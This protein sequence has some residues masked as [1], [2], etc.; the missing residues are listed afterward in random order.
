MKIIRTKRKTLALEISSNASLIIRAPQLMP[1]FLIK[2]F[3]KEKQ[4]WI[5]K[6]QRLIKDRNKK[7]Q[8]IAPSKISKEKAL[9]KI[10]KRVEHYSSLSGF[11]YNQIKITSAQKRWGSCSANNNLNFP[12]KLAL[13][14]DKVIDYVVVHELCHIKEKNHSQKFWNEVSKLMPEYKK[15]RKW[16]KDH[17]YLLK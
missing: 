7:A 4:S 17:G 6:K 11:K 5:A 13:A 9:D 2:K 8:N 3:I 15:Y 14:P 12:K 16:L 1:L 10:T